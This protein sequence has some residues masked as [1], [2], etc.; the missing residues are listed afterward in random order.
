MN[1]LTDLEI[2]KKIAEI[3][4][5]SKDRIKYFQKNADGIFRIKVDGVE[6]NPLT[7]KALCFD[8][9][10]KH[11]IDMVYVGNWSAWC[12]VYDGGQ[13]YNENPQRAICLA[14]IAKHK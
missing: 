14:I 1:E 8:L 11:K 5:I 13:L 9:M 4:G 6:Y 10:V 12:A 3:E 7:D 2:C